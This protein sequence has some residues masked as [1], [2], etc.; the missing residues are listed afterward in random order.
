MFWYLVLA[1]LIADYPLQPTWMVSNKTRWMVLA[2]HALVHFAVG[3]IVVGSARLIIWP[4]L[5]VLA[6]L[7]LVID[8]GKN[9]LNKLQ[10]KWVIM[11]YLLDQFLH[12][13]AMGVIGVWI[14]SRL[15]EQLFAPHPFWLV[16]IIGYLLVTYVWYISERIFTYANLAYRE[17]VVNQVWTRMVTRATLLT[18]M[19]YLV[20]WLSPVSISTALFV[21]LP[22]FSSKY[23]LRILFTD[24]VVSIG[25]LIF[26][27]LTL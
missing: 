9:S 26:I 3:L 25:G 20:G 11:P 10:P 5:L 1:H 27:I 18:V 6:L 8:T 17:E 7:H 16:L 24:L 23:R 22:Y 4:Q 14:G 21:K 12:F 19:L 2:L 15:D 13:V